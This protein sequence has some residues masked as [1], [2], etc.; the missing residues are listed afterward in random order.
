MTDN[1]TDNET[2]PRV[3]LD[4]GATVRCACGWWGWVHGDAYGSSSTVERD[5]PDCDTHIIVSAEVT[6]ED[7][8][9]P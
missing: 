3:G 6:I 2:R 7:G 4:E 1:D 8:G 9:E 5:C